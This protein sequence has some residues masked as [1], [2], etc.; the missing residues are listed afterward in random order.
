MHHESWSTGDN[1]GETLSAVLRRGPHFTT[2][3]TPPFGLCSCA[4]LAGQAGGWGSCAGAAASGVGAQAKVGR[5]MRGMLTGD[6]P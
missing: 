5:A 6:G 4:P 1:G 3:L 2:L